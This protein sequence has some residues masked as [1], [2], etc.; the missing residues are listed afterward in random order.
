[1]KWYIRLSSTTL[2]SNRVVGAAGAYPSW[3]LAK[4]EYSLD[5]SPIH[6]RSINEHTFSNITKKLQKYF[7]SNSVK[8]KMKK[9]KYISTGKIF[10]L[11]EVECAFGS[12][13]NCM[14]NIACHRLNSFFQVLGSSPASWNQFLKDLVVWGLRVL[15]GKSVPD[16]CS[17]LFIC[18]W[19]TQNT[20]NHKP[21]DKYLY[22]LGRCTIYPVIF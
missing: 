21:I 19:P 8:K 17:P 5:K 12:N 18:A 11:E 4:A 22:S 16:H 10:F 6:H 7:D 3:Q 1:M 13:F 15:G 9:T 20:Q 2:S 14:C